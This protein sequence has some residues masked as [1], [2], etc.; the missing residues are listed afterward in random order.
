MNDIV[1]F[2]EQF[3]EGGE[4]VSIEDRIDFRQK[5]E[6]FQD[7]LMKAFPNVTA[8]FVESCTLTHNFSDDAY[9]R[10]VFMPANSIVVG[11][12]HKKQ[13]SNI[14]SK[15]KCVVRTE[16]FGTVVYDATEKPLT[17]VSEKGTKRILWIQED[18][19]WTTIHPKKYNSV[20]EA[21]AD[22]F[23][24]FY[25]DFVRDN[26]EFSLVSIEEHCS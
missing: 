7:S 22:I 18:T 15:G 21:E 17:F 19:Y 8:E 4:I 16:Q 6:W 24:I 26:P 12:I 14:I 20:E 11:K 13:H 23:E 3:R 9:I 25:A 5:I 2:S 1:L 10:T